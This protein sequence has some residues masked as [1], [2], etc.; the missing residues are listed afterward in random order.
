[1]ANAPAIAAGVGLT[2]A[3][4]KKVVQMRREKKVLMVAK[5]LKTTVPAPP[6]PRLPQ[7]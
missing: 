6:V 2:A 5:T 4:G 7:D 3:A 1:V